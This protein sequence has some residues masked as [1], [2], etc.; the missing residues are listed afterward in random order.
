MAPSYRAHPRLYP[1]LTWVK[2]RFRDAASTSA[3]T[4]YTESGNLGVPR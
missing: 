4:I 2:R 3:D 1:Q